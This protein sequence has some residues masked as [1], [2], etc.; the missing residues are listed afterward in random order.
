[1]PTT[2]GAYDE[3]YNST[4][5]QGVG[6]DVFV[7]KFTPDMSSRVA[8][9]FIGGQN[10]ET[11]MVLSVGP[12]SCLYMVGYSNSPLLPHTDY[13]Y[14]TVWAGGDDAFLTCTSL[15]LSSVSYSS[16]LGGTSME[17]AGSMAI[18]SA[19]NVYV[20]GMTDSW[21]FP[22]T[23]GVI[24]EAYNG[25]DEPWTGEDRGGDVYVS[26]FPAE[27]FVDTD[28]DVLPDYLD[29]CPDTPNPGQEDNN[30]DGVGDACCCG[31]FTGGYTGNTDCDPNG[32]R[33][34]GDITTLIDRVYVSQEVM[35]CEAAG[36]TSGDPEGRL[37]LT[38]ITGLIDLVYVTQTQTAL[39][40]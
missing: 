26:V 16:F 8:A 11:G 40:P 7:A 38:D 28:G 5:A 20:S 9:T 13:A 39:C 31:H 24:S 18:D 3:T 21:E 33:N 29:N 1:M 25:S 34:L 27:H 19:G 12:D 30:G 4:A 2:S 36:N 14:D 35:C 15:D 22:T 23:P 37:N 6:D 10:W 32:K 17:A